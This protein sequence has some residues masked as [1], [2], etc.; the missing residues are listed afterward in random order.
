MRLADPYPNASSWPPSVEHSGTTAG[1]ACSGAYQVLRETFGFDSFRPGQER[2]I[3]AL[4]GGKH[5]LAVMPTGAGKSLCYQI[6][7]LLR[8]GLTLVVSPLIALME[9]QVS[10]LRL[11]GAA[12]FAVNSAKSRERNLQE[13]YQATSSEAALLYLAPERLMT[14]RMLAALQR[15]HVRLIVVDEAHCI[16]KWGP[17]FRP[18]YEALADLTKHLPG[19]PI[20]AFTATADE[21]TRAD[22]MKK[23]FDRAGKLFV[24]G[25]DRPNIHLSVKRNSQRSHIIEYVRARKGLS[26]I[27]YCLSRK[28]AEETSEML[29][30]AGVEAIPYH[31]GMDTAER[32]ANQDKFMTTSGVVMVATIAFGMGIDKPDIRYVLHCTIPGSVEAY[33]Q[34]LGR[35]GRDGKEAEALML[36][37]LDAIRRRRS[38]IDSTEHDNEDHRRR[39]HKRLDAL[40][41]Y[42]ES[43]K[44]RRQVLLGYF[45]EI[46]ETCGNCDLCDNPPE[47]T[48]GTKSAR[49][50]L[51]VVQGTGQR[52]GQMH[53]IDVLLGSA[54]SKVRQFGHQDLIVFGKGREFPK[55]EW[56]SF[57]LQMVA[58]GFLAI[59]Y[60]GFGG[61]S[62]TPLGKELANGVSSFSYRRD[63]AVESTGRVAAESAGQGAPEGVKSAATRE[64][65]TALSD[66]DEALFA[67]LKEVRLTL[68]RERGVPAFVIFHDTTLR[69]IA[70][71]RPESKEGFA[72][73]RGVGA[74]KLTEFAEV[75]L[76]E[77]RAASKHSQ[78]IA[79][80]PSSS[81]GGNHFVEPY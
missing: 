21:T 46:A 66:A 31:A 29:T 73:I 58:A 17:A 14:E 13:W 26:G 74:A 57:I 78:R 5:V 69:E 63:A 61:L 24:S 16:S 49:R 50:V 52:F 70:T 22:V 43:A 68:A 51:E 64:Q 28:D 1:T 36:Y 62:L 3:S 15:Q 75:F 54:T 80:V 4:L 25:F 38:L 72:A 37:G 65:T 40:I 18:E 44:C 6:P 45:G 34:E 41:G 59:D 9:D 60:Q 10:A 42:C 81:G 35:A 7:A 32:A 79:A 56:R 33:Y 27:V 23:L 11:A 77:V 19:V 71:C 55:T 20:G 67:R 12:A 30:E 53:V 76:R 48:D 2:V 39:E 8:G 47:V